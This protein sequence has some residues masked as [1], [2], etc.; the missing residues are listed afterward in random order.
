V[1]RGLVVLWHA[2]TA[3]NIDMSE[4]SDCRTAL[5][6][7]KTRRIEAEAN[8]YLTP[9][10]LMDTIVRPAKANLRSI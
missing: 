3:M 8:R 6:K 7:L 4:F 1:K 9:R 5:A 10:L 2:K